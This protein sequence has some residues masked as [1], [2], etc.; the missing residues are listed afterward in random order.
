MSRPL[1]IENGTTEVT[2]ELEE[3]VGL[4]SNQLVPAGLLATRLN[5]G[6]AQTTAKVGLEPL[7]G[8]NETILDTTGTTTTELPPGLLL[9]GASAQST[10]AGSRATAAVEM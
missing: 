9:L 5:V 1:T 2:N 6:R 10:S 3:D 4:L 8:G 7:I